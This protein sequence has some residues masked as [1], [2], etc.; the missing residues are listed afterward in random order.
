[1]G[2]DEGVSSF[3]DN[4]DT[5]DRSEFYVKQPTYSQSDFYKRGNDIYTQVKSE[6]VTNKC[7][8]K[9]KNL[10]YNPNFVDILLKKY[11]AYAP[12]WTNLMGTYIDS[13]KPASNSPVEG[14][15]SIVKNINL[16]GERNV[17]PTDYVRE[18]YIYIKA[19]TEE[20]NLNETW[21]INKNYIIMCC[22]YIYT[23]MEGALI[24][25]G[26][27]S[28]INEKFEQTLL[29]YKIIVIPILHNSH[30]AF[31]YIDTSSQTF[32]YINPVGNEEAILSV[33]FNKFKAIENNKVNNMWIARTEE[34]D[35]QNLK[36]D[37]TNCGVFVCQFLER[38]VKNEALI[39]LA[40]LSDY[41]KQM[42]DKILQYNEELTYDCLHS[43]TV[44]EPEKQCSKC[45]R[46]ICKRC[47]GDYYKDWKHFCIVCSNSY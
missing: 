41:R 13:K 24:F 19:K 10:F 4:Y 27:N 14:Y 23:C 37:K 15:F 45:Y 21:I 12:L 6:I 8:H 28:E 7:S 46:V 5:D 47:I 25:F 39:D 2:C 31:A 18:S 42:K 11:V 26:D 29:Q 1:M 20:I 22:N 40:R 34:H 44:D 30:F 16:A 36:N 32:I 43:Y 35:L 3:G 38:I 33:L 17:R 9:N